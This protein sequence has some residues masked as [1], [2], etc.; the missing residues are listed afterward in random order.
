MLTGSTPA[1]VAGSASWAHLNGGTTS[2]GSVTVKSLSG[3]AYTAT[4]NPAGAVAKASQ[5]AATQP[6]TVVIQATGGQVFNYTTDCYVLRLTVTGAY[7]GTHNYIGL[8]KLS[9]GTFTGLVAYADGPAAAYLV[10]LSASGG[11]TGTNVTAK[12]AGSSDSSAVGYSV[13]YSNYFLI[14]TGYPVVSSSKCYP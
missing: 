1:A 7:A 10:G 11:G 2:N 13:G 8:G 12:Y 6:P 3:G 14:V 9:G 5:N 4:Q